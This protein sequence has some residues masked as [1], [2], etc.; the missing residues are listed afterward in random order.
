MSSLNEVLERQDAAQTLKALKNPEGN[1]PFIYQEASK[2][3]EALLREKKEGLPGNVLVNRYSSC[4]NT[5][6]IMY[7]T[8]VFE[9]CVDR[10]LCC[11][12]WLCIHA[13]NTLPAMIAV[14]D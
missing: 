2:Y 10:C 7:V 12:P 5:H 13:Y 14:M 4:H 8:Y 9:M 6:S 1:F 3:H 11:H